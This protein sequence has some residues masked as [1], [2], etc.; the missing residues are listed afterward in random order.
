MRLTRLL[1]PL[2]VLS[3]LALASPAMAADATVGVFDF[4]FRAKEVKVGVGEKVTWNFVAAGHTTTSDRGQAESWN[5]G[6]ALEPSGATFEHTF[7]TPGRFSYVCIPHQ[8]FMKGTVVVGT[9]EHRKSYSG[10][11]KVRRGSRLTLEFE[12]LESAKVTIKL[13]GA[14]NRSA[15]RKRLRPGERSIAFRGLDDGRYRG[16]A[17]FTDDFDK[18][19]VVRFSTVIR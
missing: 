9:D 5:S 8:S 3:P 11:K 12:V 16:T 4:E 10:F 7:D 18:K 17:T 6:P 14:D 13:R 1:I 19:S 2:A 15:T